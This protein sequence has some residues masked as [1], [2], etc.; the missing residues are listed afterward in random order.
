MKKLITFLGF[1]L[2]S[3]PAFA[4]TYYASPSGGGAASC[5]DN[6][7]N[8]CSLQRAVTVAASGTNT[9]ECATG[10]YTIT[11][12]L[13]FN[14]TNTGA[15]LTIQKAAGATVTL[16]STGGTAVIDI[17]AA[18]VSGTITF[19]GIDISET[20][21]DYGVR[22]LAPEVNVV[23][24]NSSITNSDA[25]AGNAFFFVPDTTNNISL[26]TGQDTTTGLRTGATTNVKIAQQITVGGS[27]ITVNRVALLLQKIGTT[28]DYRNGDTLTVTIETNS[29][30][31]PSGTPVT[32]GTSTTILAY[33]VSDQSAE[34]SFFDFS[35]NVTLTA[36]TVY[37]IVLQ[38]SY[39]ASSTNY[40]AWSADSTSGGYAGGDS[41]TYNGTTWTASAAGFD[42]IFAVNRN[43]TRTL[44][45]TSNTMNTRSDNVRL[46]W[47]DTATISG[48]TMTSTAG[49][50]LN[51]CINGQIT[52]SGKAFNRVVFSSNTVSSTANLSQMIT[53]GTNTIAK[54]YIDSLSVIN[55]SGTVDGIM[56]PAVYLKK[57]F[58]YGNNFTVGYSGNTPFQL[59]FEVDGSDPMGVNYEPF[60]QVVIE[61]NTLYYSATTHNHLMLLGIGSE[62]GVLRNNTIRANYGSG[63]SSGGWGIVVK[64]NRWFIDGNR[65]YGGGPCIYLTSN[66]NRVTRNTCETYDATGSNAAILFRNHQDSIYGGKFGIPY[67]NYVEDNIFVSNGSSFPAIQHCDTTT[68]GSGSSTLG[69]GRT[70]PYW[71][72]RIDNNIY[73]SRDKSGMYSLGSGSST[74]SRTISD[75]IA[76]V[77]TDWASSTYSDKNSIAQY[78][79]IQNSKIDNPGLSGASSGLFSSSSSITKKKGVLNN[80][81]IGGYQ[82]SGS[83]GGRFRR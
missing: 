73:F 69:T 17:T 60:D 77:Q 44:S 25:T 56:K 76:T 2:L 35:S 52:S 46:G 65:F 19:D 54:T 30:G 3:T 71:S 45:V 29:A 41:A 18:M 34:M 55:N 32:N 37:W 75:G 78:N 58:F 63:T 1:I 64:A 61:N 4:G 36:S 24:K 74:V 33:D 22:N 50:A 47:L 31:A 8:V 23:Y 83:G 72:N 21:T 5:V 7:A 26:V 39:T 59:G 79:D 81:D 80:T 57:L 20:D 43:H 10:S 27:N 15:N 13:S 40:I 70:E 28:W 48:N 82:S 16:A 11:T 6:G 67:F 51:L 12:A 66:H 68:C 62:D 53:V 49:G 9:I 42:Y 14:A 38:G